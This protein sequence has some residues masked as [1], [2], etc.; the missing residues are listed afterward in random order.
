M[1]MLLATSFILLFECHYIALNVLYLIKEEEEEKK[2]KL[3]SIIRWKWARI[4][5]SDNTGLSYIYVILE[6]IS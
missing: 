1:S 5:M 6:Q 2:K 3:M 4:S